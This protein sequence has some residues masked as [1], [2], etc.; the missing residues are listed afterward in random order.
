MTCE[1]DICSPELVE[2][3]SPISSSATSP[4]SQ[5]SGIH[6]PAQSCVSDSPGCASS[7]AMCEPWISRESWLASMR[8]A[9]AFLARTS[10]QQD[11]APA[12]MATAPASIERSYEQ[13]T[14][15]GPSGRSL[16]TARSSESEGGMSSSAISWRSDIPGAT[17]S[18]PHLRLA[19]R[20]SA[21]AG[22]ALQD[23]PT[24]TV[25]GNYNR[26]GASARSG[27]GLA[28][29]VAMWPTPTANEIRTMETEKLLAR[30]ERCKAIAKNGNGFGLTLGNAIT[31][32]QAGVWAT[33]IARDWRSGKASQ[34]T[35]E[36][37]SRPLSEQVGGRL[38]P[39]WIEWLM[40]WPIGH[41]KSEHWETDKSRSKRRQRGS[42][43][44]GLANG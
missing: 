4:L 20:T 1:P 22:G 5:S 17:D 25:C 12:L 43:S 41:T 42:R 9:L 37:N 7:R 18:L 36:R 40:A 14:L 6:T 2:E 28:T 13:L 3:S 39:R 38:N 34:A 29:W 21:I 8:Y 44:E 33:P 15:F 23:I 16:K 24:P 27:D 19:L 30:R 26:K 35:M 32:A 31:L 10:V 11:G